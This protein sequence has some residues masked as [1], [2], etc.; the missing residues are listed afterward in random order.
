MEYLIRQ[1]KQID[2]ETVEYLQNL[3]QTNQLQLLQESVRLEQEGG[4]ASLQMDNEYN[5]K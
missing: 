5:L 1:G 2:N 3:V 4:E